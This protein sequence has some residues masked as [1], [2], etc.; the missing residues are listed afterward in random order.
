MEIAHH[1][2]VPFFSLSLSF[3][4]TLCCGC[5]QLSK[6]VN[7]RT[8]DTRKKK[9]IKLAWVW[10]FAISSLPMHAHSHSNIHW[11]HHTHSMVYTM[12]TVRWQ[13]KMEISKPFALTSTSISF[14][15]F[16]LSLISSPKICHN[17]SFSFFWQGKNK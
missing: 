14:T 13:K 2:A 6:R 11:N 17:C 4:F 10:V 12:H 16:Y 7:A 1:I 3:V 15:A 8:W 9:Y 5:T